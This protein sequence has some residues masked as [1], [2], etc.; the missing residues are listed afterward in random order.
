MTIK[1]VTKYQ[2]KTKKTI[3]QNSRTKKN[4]FKFQRLKQ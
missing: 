3:Y 4:I 2:Q 1:T